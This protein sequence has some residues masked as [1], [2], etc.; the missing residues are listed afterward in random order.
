[1]HG[2]SL[3]VF[4]LWTSKVWGGILAGNDFGL[5]ATTA[6]TRKQLFVN[7]MKTRLNTWY[8]RERRRGREIT[9]IQNMTVG[10]LGDLVGGSM[11]FHGAETNYIMEFTVELL[12]SFGAVV[13]DADALRSC[14]D[15][16]MGMLTMLRER[17]RGTFPPAE[18]EQFVGYTKVAL[19]HFR[20]FGISRPKVHQL[21]H[22]AHF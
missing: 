21:A 12:Q 19:R 16:L 8:K 14:G 4:Q 22:I 2:C 10:M 13:G 9:E 11:G 7:E 5:T 17:P 1:M 6:E 3:G 20:R 18:V 15:A